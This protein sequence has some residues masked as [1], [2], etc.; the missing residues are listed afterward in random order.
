MKCLEKERGR[1]YETANALALDI[2]HQFEQEPVTA[3]APSTLYRAGKFVRRH[4]A[5]L[6]TATALLLLLVAGAVVSAW[7]AVRA[8]R[9]ER[10]QSRL[11]Q[12]AE[13][14]K[15]RAD[16][17]AKQI[18]K[19]KEVARFNLY[20][21]QISLIQQEME[22][23]GFGPALN[24]LESQRPKE[25]EE[26]LRGFEWYYLWHECNRGLLATLRGHEVGVAA[27]AYLPDGTT[28]VSAGWDGTV[29]A[30]ALKGD[31][32]PEI[33][34][35][36]RTRVSWAVFS[37][38]GKMLAWGSADG[39]VGIWDVSR[40]AELASVKAHNGAVR[41]LAF[42]PDSRWLASGAQDQV[43]KVWDV[44]TG[45]LRGPAQ[46]FVNPPSV[47]TRVALA[48]SPDGQLLAR[49]YYGTIQ[50]YALSTGQLRQTFAG[51]RYF[52]WFLAFLPDGKTL[53]SGTPDQMK[54]W[55]LETGQEKTELARGGGQ[56]LSVSPDGTLL[57]VGQQDGSVEVSELRSGQTRWYAHTEEVRALAFSPDGNRLATAG[58]DRTIKL[59]D[60][61]SPANLLPANRG[62]SRVWSVA[63]SP[64]GSQLVYSPEGG[65]TWVVDVGTGQQITALPGF[66]LSAA[67]SPD[68]KLLAK[69]GEGECVELWDVPTWQQRAA[70]YGHTARGAAVRFSPDG[71]TLASGSS[72]GSVWLWDIASRRTLARIENQHSFPLVLSLAFS[73]DNACLASASGE[74]SMSGNVVLWDL[75]AG[76]NRVTLPRGSTSVA[77]SPDGRTLASGL[78]GGSIGLWD[79]ATGRKAGEISGHVK[80]SGSLAFFPGGKTLATCNDDGTITI[81]DLV[82]G[83]LRA[84]LRKRN[85]PVYSLAVA[86]DGRT[87][88]T[89]TEDGQVVLWRAADEREMAAQN[90]A[91][92]RL[93]ELAG[94]S[95]W[96]GRLL[97]ER[98]LHAEARDAYLHAV[99]LY[100]S[101]LAQ[102]P[103]RAQ[104]VRALSLTYNGL[105]KLVGESSQL[106]PQ[107][108][109]RALTLADK[110]ITLTEGET[111]ALLEKAACLCYKAKLLEK[112][113]ESEEALATFTRAITYAGTD[114][115]PCAWILSEARLGRSGLLQRMNRLAEAAADR[116]QALNIPRRDVR[117]RANLLDLSLF[118]NARLRGET[119]L[120]SLPTGIQ[121]LDGTEF[122]VRGLVEVSRRFPA[123]S[124]LV[125]NIPVAQICR[126]LHFLHAAVNADVVADGTQLGRY[127]VH[128]SNGQQGEIPLVQGRDLADWWEQANEQ[129]KPLVVAWTGTNSASQREGRHIRLFKTSW[130]NP[131]PD[132]AV[133]S[134]DF[135]AMD[136]VGSPFLVAITAE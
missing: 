48:F 35:R 46:Q 44:S 3:A 74:N 61:R 59:W 12:R 43:V 119:D 73:P 67:Y 18:A 99:A 98:G 51:H 7:Q 50:V 83:Q 115:N 39:A 80:F 16:V 136:K 70:F 30:W 90:P 101:A 20:V 131:Q 126:R 109:R 121:S 34:G 77:F 102:C 87:I 52:I 5:G 69:N 120:A 107:D 135:E 112:A 8:T 10:A 103:N 58:L 128:Y 97:Q 31:S 113:G 81:V 47:A 41:G 76:Q 11:R 21:A 24:L 45:E 49:S 105:F 104:C 4:K 123:Y 13:A 92:E 72:G 86:P 56:E 84:T 106:P 65:Q 53:V 33:M 118:Y 66:T 132:L 28:L 25:G 124:A 96:Q 26:D 129:G 134:I 64:D 1:R 79:P 40:H 108:C 78:L 57:A 75:A 42:S 29:R 23:Q 133:R 130:P 32:P 94:E 37:R 36:I 114:T 60:P 38:D 17:H 91:P 127:V 111:N 55:N 122:D 88:A 117:A 2:E 54:F 110:A 22:E 100:E 116:C 27:L 89:G 6:A 93:I 71:K 82:R 15:E 9:A 85:C 95:S 62:L 19:E 125:T 14:E 63:F 68:G